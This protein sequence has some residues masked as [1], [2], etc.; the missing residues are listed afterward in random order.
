MHKATV[1][2]YTQKYGRDGVVYSELS[3]TSTMKFF[4]KINNGWNPLTIYEKSAIL[5]V[6]L[7]SKYISVK[8]G[9]CQSKVYDQIHFKHKQIAVKDSNQDK[10]PI[11]SFV[12]FQ[13]LS[14]SSNMPTAQQFLL[15]LQLLFNVNSG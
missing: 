14:T 10:F 1:Q 2:Y 7:G 5:N 4:V 11:T 12:V 8:F 3:Q 6:G 15:K 9:I 13:H